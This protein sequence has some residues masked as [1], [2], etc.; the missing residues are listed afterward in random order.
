MKIIIKESISEIIIK[1]ITT[2]IIRDTYKK[3]EIITLYTTY[4]KYYQD[5]L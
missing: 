4:H 2:L 5:V 3:I 1:G